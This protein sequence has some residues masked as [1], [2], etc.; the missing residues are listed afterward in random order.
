MNINTLLGKTLVSCTGKVGDDKIIFTTT[1]GKIY[2]LFHDQE[3]CEDVYVEDICG[4]LSDLVGSPII[5]AEENSNN[6]FLPGS[7]KEIYAE[8]FTWTFYR[9]TTVKGH[10]VIRWFG[11]SNG[12]YSEKVNFD[13]IN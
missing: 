7:D 8:S 3:C 5:Q 2:K 12:S 6:D 9:L 4:E 1:D 13:K 11:E 10:V